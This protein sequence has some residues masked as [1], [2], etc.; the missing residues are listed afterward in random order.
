[1]LDS[2]AERLVDSVSSQ[3]AAR[4][5][6]TVNDAAIERADL[7]CSGFRPRSV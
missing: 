7:V 3:D 6:S 4:I 2:I 5:A 1:M